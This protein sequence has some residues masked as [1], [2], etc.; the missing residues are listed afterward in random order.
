MNSVCGMVVDVMRVWGKQGVFFF[1][2]QT[3][4]LASRT[5][6]CP[7]LLRNLPKDQRN[8]MRFVL[9]SIGRLLLTGV[10]WCR[11]VI[12]KAVRV[13]ALPVAD[14]EAPDRH[15]GE[16]EVLFRQQA[17]I[18][19]GKPK[20]PRPGTCT[21]GRM[22]WL[23]GSLSGQRLSAGDLAE[24]VLWGRL[25]YFSLLLPPVKTWELLLIFWDPIGTFR[26]MRCVEIK[27]KTFVRGWY[28]QKRQWSYSINWL[29]VDGEPGWGSCRCSC[30]KYWSYLFPCLCVLEL[31]VYM[32]V[33]HAA[34]SFES[35]PNI[36]KLKR[37]CPF[38]CLCLE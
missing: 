1:E 22:Q 15:I 26:P 37:F 16:I 24:V 25:W 11:W 17:A 20:L 4:F 34:E 18:I 14:G 2:C 6:H 28:F 32:I 10:T 12:S 19:L 7:T 8:K 38:K 29:N 21:A 33:K 9:A 13:W 5:I 36:L 3:S 23:H 30:C 27:K 35:Y 31:C